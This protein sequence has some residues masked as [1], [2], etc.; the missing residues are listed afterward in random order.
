M[1]YKLINNSENN[2]NDI[3]GT[4]LKNRGIVDVKKYIQS[5]KKDVADWQNLNNIYSAVQC[6]KKHLNNDNKIC[7]L[8]D[9]DVDGA[10]SS[11]IIYKYLKDI[12]PDVDVQLIVHTQNKS[13]GLCGDFDIPTNTA[14]LICPDSAT[15]DIIAHRQLKD[16]GI[17]VVCLDHHEQSVEVIPDAIVV[18]NQCSPNYNKDECGAAITWQFCRA[19]DDENWTDY[20]DKYIDL[21]AIANIADVMSLKSIETRASVNWG[22][23]NLKNKMLLKIF[24]AQEF[25]TKGIINP[26]TVSFYIAP[27]INSFLRMATK[28]E[29]ELLLKAFCEDESKTFEYTK[30][31]TTEPITENIYEHCVRLMKSYKGKQ[32]RLKEKGFSAITKIID[33]QG[34]DN[35]I[36]MCD[37]TKDLEQSMTGLVAIKIAEKYNRPTLLLRQQVEHPDLYGGSGRAFDYCP[38]E[39]FRGLVESCP[40]V[41]LAQGHPAAF[42]V[43]IPTKDV[44]NATLW[45]N[46]KLSDVDFAK[47][48]RVDFEV[49]SSKIDAY[50]CNEVDKYKSVWAK[51]VEEPLFAITNITLH[52]KD[53][54][55]QGKDNNS[56]AFECNGIKYVQ[57][58]MPEDAPLLQY[59]NSW[60]DPE[61]KITFDVV[62]TCAL[63][64]YQ[65]VLQPQCIIKDV[66]ITEQSD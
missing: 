41:T 44:N 23:C 31:G 42:G 47:I 36:I 38:I 6:V 13:H 64:D 1:K 48:Y 55:V 51:E 58:K 56:V 50:V 49:D 11:T 21:V 46:D 63:N 33:A 29:R 35:K 62:A 43:E 30:R 18:N 5:S 20:A 24:E 53:I 59:V 3:I 17:D 27:L 8:S 65:G 40:Y 37:C 25:S 4:T 34:T 7:I 60:G 39:D 19:F 26:F 57:F 54:Y 52:R 66:Q 15:N 2:I 32:D 16:Q 10:C 12:K 45:F 22:L 61:D 14:L 9:T 28:D